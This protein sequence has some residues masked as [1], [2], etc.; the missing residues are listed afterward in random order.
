MVTSS[1]ALRALVCGLAVIFGAAASPSAH[2][3]PIVNLSGWTFGSGNTVNVAN[4][5]HN[6]P[7]GGFSGSISGFGAPFDS[8]SFQTYCVELTQFFYL[9]SG[10]MTGYSI[11]AGSAYAEWTLPTTSNRIGQLITYVNSHPGAVDT[12]AESTSLQLAIWNS[13]YDSDNTLGGGSFYDT[14]SYAAYADTLLAASASTVSNLGVY[15]LTSRD[16]Q[17]F[18]VTTPV[19][20]PETYALVLAGLAAMVSVKRRRARMRS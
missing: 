6:G 20:E 11:V 5:A 7:A 2:A 1:K 17:D 18:L 10:D 3:A 19:P 14:T 13:I 16:S 8:A 9:P 4:P 12:A 15:V